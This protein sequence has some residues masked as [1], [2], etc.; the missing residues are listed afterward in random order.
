MQFASFIPEI[1]KA[2]DYHADFSYTAL[3]GGD[4]NS[5]YLIK[6]GSD[7][8]VAK[9]NSQNKFPQMLEKEGLALQYY[10]KQVNRLNYPDPLNWGEISGIQFLL[11]KYTAPSDNKTDL[12]GQERL[13]KLLAKQHQ[14]SADYFGW[15]YDNYIGN[16]KQMNKKHTEWA[17]F[18][19]E[20]RLLEQ[21]R[22]AFDQ[23]KLSVK[24]VKGLEK[25]CLEL[26]SIF[27]PEQ[28]ALLHGDLWSGNYFITKKQEPFLYDPAIYFGH[29]EIDIGMTQLFGGFSQTFIDAYQEYYPLEKGWENRLIF[30]QLYPNLVHLNLFGEAYKGSVLQA[31][32]SFT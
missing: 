19:A 6:C 8:I 23:K 27:S 16:L 10:Q 3:S 4:I 12:D 17:V 24:E 7:S 29:R 30:S 32:D 25:L 1:L 5:V 14:V 21:A 2:C 9:I 11:L 28:P 18:Y 22:L 26:P 20:N 31:I 15:E 13:G